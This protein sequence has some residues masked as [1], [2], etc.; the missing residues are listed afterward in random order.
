MEH[1]STYLALIALAPA[2]LEAQASP[3]PSADLV[4]TNGRIYTVD[5]TRPMVSALAVR[6]GR[7][8][9]VGSDVE[10][11]ALVSPSTQVIDLHGATVVPGFVDAHA[12]LLGLG[13]MLRRVNLAGS[14][15]YDEVIARVKTFSKNVKPGEWIL[16]RGWDQN[17]WTPKEFPAHDALSRAFP[18]NPVVLKR[19]DGHALLANARALELARVTAATADPPGG[20]IIRTASGAP[21]GVFVDNAQSL[22]ERAVPSPTRE[23][24]RKA[25][26]AAIAEAN[27]WGLTGVHDPG[28]DA[29]TIG[30]YEELARAGN[31]NL[32]NYVMLS[33]PGDPGS[34]TTLRNPY[35]QRGP[36][37]ALYDGHLWIR[38]L[39]LYADGALGSRGAAMLAPYADERSNSGLLV[40]RPEHI[41]AWADTA[42]RRGFQV[43]VHAIGDRGNRIV[44]DA[45]DSAL[46]KFPKAD[47]RFRIEHAQVVSPE[48]IPRFAKLGVIP[49]MQ[50]TH[51]TSDMRWAEARVGPQRIRGAYAWRSLLNTGVIIPNGTDFPVEEVNPLLTFH[52][53]VTRQDPTNWPAGGWYPEQK[54]TREEALQ[55][56]TI[57]PAY[58]GFQESMLGS[59]TPGK[60]ADFVVLTRDI[61]HVPDTE[62]LDARVSSTWIGGKRVYEAK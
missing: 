41:R 10:A 27:R 28:E 1:L 51:Q 53:A 22:V 18:N 30:I 35:I 58:A 26:L 12:H 9:F 25:I 61:M 14:S 55:S 50:A 16:G 44:L 59:L 52:A 19:V 4:L 60:Y 46:K 5:D 23:D 62:I 29:E 47:H 49:S 43:N 48:D 54:M 17:R 42:L 37:S 24:T 31:Y 8:L 56:M 20:R 36:Q 2:M 40:S 3:S 15:S 38:A 34:D 6:G 33:D 45:F 7:V 13:N 32:R 57:W 21:A 39:K 11:R